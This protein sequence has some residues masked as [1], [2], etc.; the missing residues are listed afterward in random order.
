MS[1]VDRYAAN[2]FAHLVIEVFTSG[3]DNTVCALVTDADDDELVVTVRYCG[4]EVLKQTVSGRTGCRLCYDQL[5]VT[6]RLDQLL[7]KDFGETVFTAE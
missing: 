2:N 4:R 1:H 5:H 7:P 6:E 3:V